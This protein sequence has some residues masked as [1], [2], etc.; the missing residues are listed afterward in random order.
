MSLAAGDLRHRI[1]IET[2]TRQVDETG[3]T[4]VTWSA[5]AE[6]WAEVKPLGSREVVVADQVQGQASYLVRMRWNPPVITS[7][8]RIVWNGK[9]LNLSGPPRDPDGLKVEMLL[10]CTEG[11]GNGRV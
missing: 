4:I 7:D 5:S 10:D 1:T 8:C 3:E 9:T 2:P 11:L 6:Y